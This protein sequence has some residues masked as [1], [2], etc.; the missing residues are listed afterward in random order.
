MIMTKPEVAR[1]IYIGNI[2]YPVHSLGPGTRIGI[3]LTGCHRNCHGCISPEFKI[4]H[5]T[6]RINT[7]DLLKTMKRVFKN[8]NVDGITISG[9]EPFL[10]PGALAILV[11]GLHRLFSHRSSKI[12]ILVYTGFTLQELKNMRKE[13]VHS[14]LSNISVLIDGQYLE[15]EN[16]NS[17]LRGSDNQI[18]HY[19]DPKCKKKYNEYMKEGNSLQ[20]FSEGNHIIT[21]GIKG[22]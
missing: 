10:Q 6:E 18:I 3:W 1:H 12:D 21:V 5:P 16:N 22:D 19:L 17:P 7:E 20:V 13:S 14:I 2:L 11:E 8:I 4:Q 9:G 15:K